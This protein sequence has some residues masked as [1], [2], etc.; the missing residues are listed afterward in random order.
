[1]IGFELARIELGANLRYNDY[2]TIMRDAGFH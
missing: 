2:S 1:M